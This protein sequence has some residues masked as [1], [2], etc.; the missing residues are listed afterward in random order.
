MQTPSAICLVTLP[1]NQFIILLSGSK[2]LSDFFFFLRTWQS[3]LRPHARAERERERE[4]T[5]C[6]HKKLT[7][8]GSLSIRTVYPKLIKK[9]LVFNK[10]IST[11]CK[12]WRPKEKERESE[13][14]RGVDALATCIVRM[15]CQC[16]VHL[17]DHTKQSAKKTLLLPLPDDA[18]D[19]LGKYNFSRSMFIYTA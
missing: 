2:H 6:W 18:A 12:S 16:Q 3:G 1:H 14:G 17:R 5:R 11:P 7:W 10:Q 19:E 9:G 4:T 13:G 15:Q 8:L